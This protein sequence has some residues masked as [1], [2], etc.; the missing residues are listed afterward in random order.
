MRKNT[1][2]ALKESV[3]DSNRLRK[4]LR[5]NFLTKERKEIR[6][7]LVYLTY[8]FS[9]CRV[10]LQY[11]VIDNEYPDVEMSFEDLEAFIKKLGS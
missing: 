4:I 5:E 2:D 11:Y 8:D 9:V 1:L 10:L 7:N 6:L 3:G